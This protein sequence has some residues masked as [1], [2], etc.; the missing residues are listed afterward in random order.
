MTKTT[1]TLRLN[2]FI[3]NSGLCTRREADELI[4]KGEIKVN[5]KVEKTL[6]IQVRVGVDKVEHLNKKLSGEAMRF[7]LINK[8]SSY[9][10]EGKGGKSIFALMHD[11][12]EERVYPINPLDVLDVGLQLF[13][14]DEG[15]RTRI[16]NNGTKEPS[17]Y[18]IE[19]SEKLSE[20]KISLLRKGIKVGKSLFEVN[21][22]VLTDGG[23]GKAV[24]LVP[25]VDNAKKIKAALRIA[26]LQVEKFDRVMYAGLSKKNLPRGRWRILSEKEVAFLRMGAQ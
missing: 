25:K 4:K 23:E 20:E 1:K 14:N 7:V 10:V 18:H 11:A 13:T 24:G 5:G 2:R 17:L 16:K 3:S 8:P 22:V 12:C 15:L 6:G 9:V 26:G 19:F 21:E